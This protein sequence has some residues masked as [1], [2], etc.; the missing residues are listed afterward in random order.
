MK[1]KYMELIVE[2]SKQAIS[3]KEKLF[4]NLIQIDLAR[5]TNEVQNPNLILNSLPLT[6]QDF[7]EQVDILKLLSLEKFYGILEY[8]QDDVE[9][10]LVDYLTHNEEIE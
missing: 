10:W 4:R 8:G 1:V 7:N 5:S 3:R 9:N 2:S 6:K